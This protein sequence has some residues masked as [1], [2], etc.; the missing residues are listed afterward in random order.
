MQFSVKVV[1][2]SVVNTTDLLSYL[3]NNRAQATIHLQLEDAP[4]LEWVRVDDIGFLN[5]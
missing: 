3:L 5:F 2:G 1:E 4:A